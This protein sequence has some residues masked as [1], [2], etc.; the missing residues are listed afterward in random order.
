M[1]ALDRLFVLCYTDCIPQ[2][3]RKFTLVEV[4]LGHDMTV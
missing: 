4:A 1:G 3:L 2:G